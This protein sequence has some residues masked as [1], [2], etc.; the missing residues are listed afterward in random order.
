MAMGRAYKWIFLSFFFICQVGWAKYRDMNLTLSGAWN[1][2]LGDY[3]LLKNLY[4]YSLS[5]SY[6]M[7]N[8]STV[9][10]SVIRIE[11]GYNFE[12]L[13]NGSLSSKENADWSM[14]IGTIG[15]RYH[16]EWDFFLN[17]SIGAGMGYQAWQTSS[18]YFETRHGE[19][20]VYYALGNLEYP[21]EEWLSIGI[22]FQA[23][24]FPLNTKIERKTEFTTAGTKEIFYDKIKHSWIISTGLGINLKI[25]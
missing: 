7:N 6:W 11:G 22:F 14:T 24:Y 2:G 1:F 12:V 15:V 8:T 10:L 5:F 17:A 13:Y 25:R 3:E 23:F 4:S 16:P 21:I 18:D 20:A 9:D 19:S